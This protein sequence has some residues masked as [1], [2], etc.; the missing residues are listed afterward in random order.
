MIHRSFT[1]LI[2]E[3]FSGYNGGKFRQDV[4]AGLTV[5]AVALPL[6]LAFGVASGATAAAGLIT[7]ILSGLI[8]GGLSGAPYQI[9]GPTGAMSAVLI[10][11]AEKNG[12][13]GIWIAGALA[14]ILLL[15]IGIVRLG[16]FIA[17]VPAPV[18]AGF[19]T[20]IALIIAIGQ[21]DNLLGIQTNKAHSAALKLLG[22][23][24]TDFTP[25]WQALVLGTLVIFTMALWPKNWGARF[26]GSLAGIFFA[27]VLNAFF[28]VSV[29]VIGKIPQTLVLDDRLTLDMIPFNQL[30]D[31]VAPALTI[32]ALGAVESLLC[33]AVA[34]NMTGIRLQ[35]NQEL[36]AQGVGNLIIPFLGGVPATAA[37]ARSS[38][39][40]KSGGQTRIVSIVHALGLLGSMFILGPIM[41]EIPLAALAGVLMVTA[42][43]MNEW[44]AIHYIFGRRFKTGMITFLVTMVAT[45]VLDLTEAIL[46]GAFLSG[47]IFLNQ[48]A[49]I[50]IDVQEVDPEKLRKRGIEN[51]GN[52]RHVRVAYLTGPLFFAATSNFNEAFARLEST[53]ALIL[54][55]RGVP[56]ID[57]SGLQ[58]MATL[59]HKLQARGITV[60]ATALNADVLRMMERGGIM[61]AIGSENLFWS[62]DQAIVALEKRYC[63]YC[64][65]EK[66]AVAEEEDVTV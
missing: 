13:P 65:D 46:L 59:L 5:A 58:S 36:V 2:K 8:I 28:D 12:L 17:F 40:I 10:V 14:G 62:S 15:V 18:I 50:D 38:V 51:A 22:Y 35:A 20:G 47:A 37:I 57:T 64:A 23:F 52:C 26:P 45:V 63:R 29:P 49:S 54:S 27:T 55:M 9:S 41:S 44:E 39:G 3:E 61:S 42:W 21:L 32:T 60:C 33:G 43:R 19:T 31:F 4:M 1:A 34:S 7:A 6:A 16:R 56:L 66:I 11:L 25:D 24:Q 30:K 53:R 48:S